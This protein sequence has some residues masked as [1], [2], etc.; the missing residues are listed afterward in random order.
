MYV[1]EN[2]KRIKIFVGDMNKKIET[3]MIPLKKLELN[4]GQID[5]LSKNPR[6]IKGE[7]FEKL[8]KSL[9]DSPEF[10]EAR[11]LL[12][13]PKGEKYVVI[14]GN[15]RLRAARELKFEQIPCYVFPE[16]T[17]VDKLK[18]YAVKDNVD[19]GNWDWDELGNNWDVGELTDWGVDCSFLGDDSN[20][21]GIEDGALSGLEE[22][23]FQNQLREET[24][25]FQ[26]S[27]VMPLD[28]K[29]QIDAFI[30]KNGKAYIVDKIVEL[31]CFENDVIEGTLECKDNCDK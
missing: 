18:E 20:D 17:P 5:G 8:K 11:P 15:M 3:V 22:G 24:N 1:K 12:A 6:Y 31:C 9:S 29:P 26:M 25:S 14:A 4:E 21:F 28:K 27:F 30:K 19:F 16:G 10:L 23:G 2:I 13:Y 7:E